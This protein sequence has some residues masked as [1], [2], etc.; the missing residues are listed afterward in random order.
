LVGYNE[1]TITN[2]Y[3][4][5]SVE[6]KYRV[7]GLVGMNGTSW[8]EG[9]ITNCYSA[10]KVSG[11]RYVGGLVGVKAG[12]VVNSFWDI[13]TSEQAISASGEGKTTAQMRMADTFLHWGSCGQVWTIN[14]GVDYPRLAWQQRPG[15]PITGIFPFEGDGVPGSPYLIHTAEELNAIRLFPCVWDKHFK[16]MANIDLSQYTG[17]D[18]NVIVRFSGTFDGNGHTISNFTYILKDTSYIGLFGDVSGVIK[19]LGLIDPN[20]VA[21]KERYVG[22]LVGLLDNGTITNCYVEGGSVSGHTFV[23]KLVG[24]NNYGTISECYST[25]SVS[26]S[27]CVGGLVGR[28]EYG[29]ITSCYSIVSVSGDDGAVGGLVGDNKDTITNCYSAGSVSGVS[30]VGGLVGRNWEATISNCYSMT[31]VS[32]DEDVGGLAGYHSKGTIY[33]C[34]STGSVTG[35]EDV[36][37]LLGKIIRYGQ[38][39]HSFWD[40]ETSGQDWSAGG[41]GL[42]TGQMQMMSTFTD[43]GWDFVGETVN[44]IEDIWFIPRQGYP[45]LWWQGLQV[46]MKLNPATLNCHSKGNWVKAHLTLPQGFTVADVDSDRPA[47]LHSFGFQSAPLYVFV[48]NNGLVQIEAAFERSALCS[49]AGDWPDTLTVA[50]FLT[51]GNIFLGTSKVRIIAPGIK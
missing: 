47:V 29:T 16:L 45:R 18:F 20:L 34:Y 23:G 32:G 41:T 12:Y 38:V 35:V 42:P 17:T 27:S 5:G 51:D 7:G 30:S 39:M 33:N 11:K 44:E 22:L 9:A 3:A 10:G 15:E 21:Q 19:N 24:C 2:S 36:G 46:P 26:G 14:E 37:G 40:I 28:N 8:G 49:L 31:S 25:G 50:A 43:A 4:A 13:E 6:G 1:G 48:N